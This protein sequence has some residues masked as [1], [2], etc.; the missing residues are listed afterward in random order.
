M[1]PLS[2]LHQIVASVLRI[3]ADKIGPAA[4]MDTV[5]TWNS[6]THIE[7]V[8]TLEEQFAI[9]LTDDEIA[10]MTSLAQVQRV[11]RERGVLAP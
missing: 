4:N 1:E 5:D 9:Q 7:F 11:L 10:G 6:L 8:T 2:T 3:S